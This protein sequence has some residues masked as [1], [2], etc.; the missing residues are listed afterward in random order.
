[1]YLEK[2]EENRE[3][4]IGGGEK[5]PPLHAARNRGGDTTHSRDGKRGRRYELSHHTGRSGEKEELHLT[6]A[7]KA[8]HLYLPWTRGRKKLILS[9]EKKK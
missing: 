1:L 7:K 6:L 9:P 4:K 3:R 8:A 5:E 2:R